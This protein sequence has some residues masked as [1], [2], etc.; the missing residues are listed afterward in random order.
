MKH[1]TSAVFIL[2]IA[3][4]AAVPS[5]FQQIISLKEAAG[6]R[7]SAGIWNALLSLHGQK[8]QVAPKANTGGSIPEIAAARS[9]EA[10]QGSNQP[11]AQ[12]AASRPREKPGTA[13]PRAAE[14]AEVADHDSLIELAQLENLPYV[15]SL[16][17]ADEDR[18]VVHAP[19][20]PP[21]S[22][23]RAPSPKVFKTLNA[24]KAVG[25]VGNIERLVVDN[26]RHL[27]GRE[28]K[29]EAARWAVGQRA[30][31]RAARL[32][33]RRQGEYVFRVESGN[34]CGRQEECSG[35]LEVDATN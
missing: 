28:D 8:V 35:A 12:V 15:L 22:P 10:P 3:S 29:K 11:R 19:P 23:V 34:P 13:S 17:E 33:R 1:R 21:A 31:Q 16:I 24:L 18:V 32:E 9:K 27:R 26:V 2:A 20:A 6:N 4:L 14:V 7:V 30:A 5:A 25:N